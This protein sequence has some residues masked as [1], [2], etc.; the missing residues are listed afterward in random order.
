MEDL[1]SLMDK[2]GIRYD[3]YWELSN[4][5]QGIYTFYKDEEKY[6]YI[7]DSAAHALIWFAD[8][9][10]IEIELLECQDLLP[11]D[12]RYCLYAFEQKENDYDS[13]SELEYELNSVGWIIDY[14]LDAVPYGLR[15]MDL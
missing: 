2:I 3:F 1:M 13:C 5:S 12:V 10:D 7:A 9:V 14:G 11:I 8:K 15:P 4:P 6:R